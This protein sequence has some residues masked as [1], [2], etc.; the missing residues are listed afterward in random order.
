MK[1]SPHKNNCA[2]ESLIFKRM[3]CPEF[4]QERLWC[5]FDCRL[6]PRIE[7]EFRVA[8]LAKITP[9]IA[10]LLRV[11]IGSEAKETRRQRDTDINK[12]ILK[13]KTVYAVE[14]KFQDHF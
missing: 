3:V 8:R 10:L 13:R 2:F 1:Y 12:A 14:A 7:R 6:R 5:L 9:H 11:Y 4:K